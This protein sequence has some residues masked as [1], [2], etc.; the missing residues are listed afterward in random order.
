MAA[1]TSINGSAFVQVE[2][3]LANRFPFV[4]SQNVTIP[5]TLYLTKQ[6]SL[7]CVSC[8]LCFLKINIYQTPMGTQDIEYLD[9][10]EIL[11]S[12]SRIEDMLFNI[13]QDL[14]KGSIRVF[15]G[16]AS[17]LVPFTSDFSVR[18]PLAK[19]F[20]VFFLFLF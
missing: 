10:L 20:F 14:L 1:G 18:I 8:Q 4:S 11:L 16:V 3:S 15:A 7:L 5:V 13:P 9:S 12:H 19:S 17:T 2:V 6:F